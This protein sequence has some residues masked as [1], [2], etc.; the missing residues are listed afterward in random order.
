V[1]TADERKPELPL[2]RQASVNPYDR[3][4][5]ALGVVE[6]ASR[7][8]AIVAPEPGMVMDVLVDVNDRVETG[9]PLFRLDARRLDAD[10]IRAVAAVAAG[11]AEV[12]RWHALPRAEDLPPLEASLAAAEALVRD[13]EEQLSLTRTASQRG[14]GTER[15]LSRAAFSL[16]A[17]RAEALRA[18]AE[19][20]RMKSGGWRADLA[21]AEAKLASLKAEVEALR[22]LKERMTVRSPRAGRVLRRQVEPGEYASTD[23]ARPAFIIADLDHLHIRA[24]VDEEDIAVIS[25]AAAGQAPVKALARTRGAVVADLP[26]EF[27]RI[28]PFARPKSDLMGTNAERVDTR[29]IDV[30]FRV[31]TMPATPVYPGQAVDVF[32]DENPA[33]K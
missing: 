26:L 16:E 6:P 2:A 19:L 14:S 30:V 17:A 1:A 21:V 9:T 12:A 8:V 13:R 24:Q 22:L 3:G 18:K 7:S 33:T 32:V 27:V 10:L 28:E 31:T 5:A 23:G 25:R 4:V 20:A 29:V 15:D 11:E